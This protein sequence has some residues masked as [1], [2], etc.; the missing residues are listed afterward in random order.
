MRYGIFPDKR[1]S[2]SIG[3]RKELMSSS[4]YKCDKCGKVFDP[5]EYLNY[6]NHRGTCNGK[7]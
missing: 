6:L 7:L 2:Q 4:P 1:Y 5:G 3:G